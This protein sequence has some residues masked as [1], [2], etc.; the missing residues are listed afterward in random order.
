MMVSASKVPLGNS[1]LRWAAIVEVVAEAFIMQFSIVCSSYGHYDDLSAVM[2]QF[3]KHYLIEDSQQTLT[4]VSIFLRDMYRVLSLN[5]DYSGDVKTEFFLK[6]GLYQKTLSMQASLGYRGAERH[7]SLSS[8]IAYATLQLR[9]A[10]LTFAMGVKP[11]PHGGG[12]TGEAEAQ[13][14]GGLNL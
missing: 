2:Q 7:R 10:A 3:L 11:N 14:A 12:L 1:E 9:W 13:R 6:N 8:K 4:F 5:V